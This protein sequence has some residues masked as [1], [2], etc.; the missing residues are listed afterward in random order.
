MKKPFCCGAGG[1][2][3][4]T[5]RDCGGIYPDAKYSQV[6]RF[7]FIEDAEFKFP[8][9]LLKVVTGFKIQIEVFPVIECDNSGNKKY[10]KSNF[11]VFECQDDDDYIVVS[12]HEDLVVGE[13][14][15]ELICHFKMGES[16]VVQLADE[17]AYMCGLDDRYEPEMYLFTNDGHRA[18]L[19]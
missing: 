19:I 14:T 5:I 3:A 8:A 18:Y 2:L 4:F 13:Y 1:G 10:F 17:Y 11:Y 7:S 12:Q 16:L 15:P 9:K 6:Y